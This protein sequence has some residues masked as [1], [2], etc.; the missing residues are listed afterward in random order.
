MLDVLAGMQAV[1]L[2][3]FTS[4]PALAVPR[5]CPF[6]NQPALAVPKG[7]PFTH[8]PA[9]AVLRGILLSELAMAMFAWIGPVA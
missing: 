9:L 8:Q 2:P 4:Q 7:N 6:T 3:A 1:A 5:G